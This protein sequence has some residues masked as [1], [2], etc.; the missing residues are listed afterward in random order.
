MKKLIFSSLLLAVMFIFGSC[1]KDDTPAPGQEVVEFDI[2]YNIF[3]ASNAVTSTSQSK[4]L[5][6]VLSAANQDKVNYVYSPSGIFRNKSYISVTG[7]TNVGGT[8]NNVSFTTT[9]KKI[10]FSL[11]IPTVSNDTIFYD[12]AYTDLLKLIG[13]YMASNKSIS[14]ALNYTA[15]NANISEG[16]VKLHISTA[17]NW[18]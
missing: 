9:D 3:V 8:L 16:V 15:G 11:P 1:S 2:Q 12:D 18:K 6:D 17:F 7:L 4:Q 14:L 13:D 5:K 10:N